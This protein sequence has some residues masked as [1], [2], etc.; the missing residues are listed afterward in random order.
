[1]QW[2]IFCRVIDNF[3]D[4]GVCWRL[5]ADLAHRGHAVRLWVDDTSALAW[6]APGAAE[7]Q[8]P[9]V[10]VHPWGD[11]QTPAVLQALP[12][13][14]VWVEGFG[15][16]IAPEFIATC[17]M[18]T[19][20]SGQNDHKPPVWINLEYLSAEAYVERCHAL[21]SPV[22]QGPAQ[23]WTKHFYYPGFTAGT[24]G[25]IREPDYL[26]R[27]AAFDTE[28]RRNWLAQRGIAW[29]DQR[30]VSLFCYEPP[31]LAEFLQGLVESD[32]P[33]LLLVTPGRARQAVEVLLAQWGWPSTG[34]GSL[35]LHWLQPLTQCGFDELLWA[36]DLNL[37]RG[38]DSLVRAIWAGQPWLWQIY[39]QDDG[40]HADKLQ[41]LL[42]QMQAPASLHAAQCAWNGLAA[43]A[44][45]GP[46]ALDWGALPLAEWSA[47]AH[48][49]R[50]RLLQMD[51]LT[52]QLTD[53][54]QKKR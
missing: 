46:Q 41:A 40:A 53:F 39:P 6:M 23:G 5:C 7:G 21:P 17:V 13:A 10:Q 18:N 51:D 32:I 9:G 42:D 30:V 45:A 36:C 16:E 28:A 14:D 4:I 31:A 19:R 44:G 43:T 8:W 35:A 29:Q 54:V 37:V 15:C 26:A 11:A 2:D 1:M 12:P 27:Q 52:S 38:E 20:A 3:G 34:K 47:A 48:A 22:M 50:H 49:W 24:G 33:T 25:L